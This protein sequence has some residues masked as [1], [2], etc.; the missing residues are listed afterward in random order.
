MKIVESIKNL[1]TDKR[2]LFIVA[3][4]L[5]G[6]VMLVLSE[7]IPEEKSKADYDSEISQ[8]LNITDY[9]KNLEE[10]LTRL[11]ESV[12]GA[13]KVRVMITIDST[14]ESV[15]ATEN[16]TNERTDEKKYV[17]IKENGED[18]GLLLKVTQPAIRGAA[19]I[20]DGADSSEVRQEITGV[21][22]AVLGIST[23]RVNIAKMKPGNGG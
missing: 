4:G 20:C 19:V 22:T 16:K 8:E 17:L 10:R 2:L 9:E 18:D 1:K 21:V 3:V 7:L 14:N 12:E 23:N 5:I 13:G 6:V 15:Y 11:L